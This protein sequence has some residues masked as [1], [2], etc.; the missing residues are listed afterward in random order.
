MFKKLA[1]AACLSSLACGALAADSVK[2]GLMTTLSGGGA[3]LGIDIR[4]G[5]N[6]AMKHLNR[7]LGGLS[8]E[9]TVADD[10]QNP[11]TAKQIAERFIKRDK[12]DLATGVVFS[13]IML[14]VGPAF[15]DAETFYISANAGPSQYAG[16]QCNPY[17]FNVAWQNDNLH[18]AM[19]KYMQDKGIK[20]AV[21]L[22]P[23]YP[24]G[25]DAM[26]GVKYYY[27]GEVADEIMTKLGQLDYAAEIA[28]IRAANAEALYIFLPGAM[29]VNFLKQYANSGLMKK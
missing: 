17:F 4:D 24:G 28:Q 21:L 29:G 8:A 5:F 14:A 23:N 25:K 10:G 27:K 1:L 13:N 9:V 26:A 15:F 20:K 19:G 6:L 12:V 2:V 18:E 16:A 7:K 22:A 3:A 11:E